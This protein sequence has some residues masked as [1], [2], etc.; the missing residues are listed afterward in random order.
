LRCE[1]L[2]GVETLVNLPIGKLGGNVTRQSS[3]DKPPA[4]TN[5]LDSG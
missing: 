1:H 5:R 3:T 4:L 2:I